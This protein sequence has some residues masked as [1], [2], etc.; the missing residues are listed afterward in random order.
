MKKP[1]LLL[2]FVP[3]IILVAII[4]VSIFV[5]KGEITSGPAQIALI[6]AAVPVH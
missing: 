1:G 5:Y 6:S 4:I 2:S 3:V